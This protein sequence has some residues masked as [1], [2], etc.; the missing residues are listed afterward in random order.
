M[1][2][3]RPRSH[4]IK[5]FHRSA[6]NCQF[7]VTLLD[8][9]PLS[10]DAHRR[11]M[12][13]HYLRGVDETG[14]PYAIDDPLARQLAALRSHADTQ[15]T[16]LG[17]VRALCAFAPVFGDLAGDERLA[18]VVADHLATLETRGVSAALAT[19]AC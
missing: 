14:A 8:A 12:R 15:P 10:E 17:R 3:P 13:L 18:V 11:V 19:A 7:S 5:A 16:T 2:L 4:P 1:P 6:Q 9:E